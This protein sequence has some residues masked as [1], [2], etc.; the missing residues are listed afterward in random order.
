MWEVHSCSD[1]GDNGGDAEALFVEGCVG[2]FN[3]TCDFIVYNNTAIVMKN[4][5]FKYRI[6]YCSHFSCLVGVWMHKLWESLKRGSFW[7]RSE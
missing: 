3:R 5:Y 4:R 7:I 1:S 2:F 6:L